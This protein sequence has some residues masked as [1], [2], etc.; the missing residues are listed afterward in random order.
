VD[1]L[2]RIDAPAPDLVIL[3]IAMPRMDGLELFERLRRQGNPVPLI[4]V[5]SQPVS[6]ARSMAWTPQG[7]SRSRSI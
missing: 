7:S 4:V 5:S 3:D 6:L 2:E 1:A